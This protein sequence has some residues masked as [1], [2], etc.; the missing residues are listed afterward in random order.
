MENSLVERPA[1]I[2]ALC[3]AFW[4]CQMKLNDEND[5]GD[6][7][8]VLLGWINFSILLLSMLQVCSVLPITPQIQ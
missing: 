5:F 1:L 4:S 2:E 6:G 7:C 8:F 3:Q